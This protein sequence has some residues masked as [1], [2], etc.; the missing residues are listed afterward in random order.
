MLPLN[1][2]TVPALAHG[3][4][5]RSAGFFPR[6]HLVS[7][8]TTCLPAESR[9]TALTLNLQVTA[10]SPTDCIFDTTFDEPTLSSLCLGCAPVG[11]PDSQD[12]PLLHFVR[13][14]SNC[15]ETAKKIVNMQ[16]IEISPTEFDLIVVGTGVEESLIAR[17][18]PNSA[19]LV[20]TFVGTVT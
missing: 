12:Q 11:V 14:W 8:S 1:V 2:V 17:L 15:A 19:V 6:T 9:I 18:V 3:R 16:E 20:G 7:C 13:G 10:L 4:A 5:D